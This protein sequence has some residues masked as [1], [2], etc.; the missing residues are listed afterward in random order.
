MLMISFGP[1]VDTIG[2]DAEVRILHLHLRVSSMCVTF[3]ASV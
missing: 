2:S 1:E 3:V